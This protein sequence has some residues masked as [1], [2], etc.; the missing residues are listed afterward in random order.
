MVNP[1]PF[2]VLVVGGGL[3]GMLT[4]RELRREGMRVALVER[5]ATGS[6]STWAGGG[7][8][9]PLHPWCYPE[10][11]NALAAWSQDGYP[12]LLAALADESGVDP[13]YRRSGL[14]VV[15]G[16]DADEAQAWAARWRRTLERVDGAAAL[17]LEP[18]LGLSVESAVWLPEVGQVRNPR[19]GQALRGSLLAA[20]VTLL[21]HR[22]VTGFALQGERITGVETPE[23]EIA[24][25]AVVVASG[26]WSGSL[27]GGL[28]LPVPVEPVRGQMLL[29][30]AEPGVVSRILLD[31]SRYVIP[32][33]DGRVLV[34]STMERVGFDKSTTESALHAL[35]AAAARLVP[36]LAHYPL[37]RH[38]AGLRPG[39]PRGVPYICAH[40]RIEGLFI[41]AGHF[42]NGVV[43]GPASARLL[44][45]L[46]LERE[47]ILD[48][49]PYRLSGNIDP[50]QASPV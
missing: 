10:A 44:T 3:I 47:P 26:A 27:L 12:E 21:E 19:L 48:P 39:S 4:A 50:D 22:P 37:E 31:D 36:A 41:N 1:A 28:G 35:Q 32:R 15:E 29:F 13:E 8:L 24:A 14:L 17:A 16:F 49:S 2:D 33:R 9:S 34:G 38:W 5:G 43:M 45:D 30:H 46:L 42:R 11:V 18:S 25:G 20:G 40:P 6:E 23:G 7:I